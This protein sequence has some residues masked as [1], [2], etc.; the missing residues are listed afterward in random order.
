[1]AFFNYLILLIFSY[2]FYFCTENLSHFSFYTCEVSVFLCFLMCITL[3]EITIWKQQFL[4]T[5]YIFK[6]I[7]YKLKICHILKTKFKMFVYERPTRSPYDAVLYT[8]KWTLEN[9]S[10]PLLM[11]SSV[12]VALSRKQKWYSMC[13][14]TILK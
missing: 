2:P 11:C 8:C 4:N 7:E 10:R 6:F 3:R 9:N 1:M 13:I 5:E 14:Y 12:T